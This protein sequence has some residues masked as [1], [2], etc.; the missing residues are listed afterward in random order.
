[1][2]PVQQIMTEQIVR[3]NERVKFCKGILQ[4]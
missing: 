1:M 4:A 3:W 2:Y